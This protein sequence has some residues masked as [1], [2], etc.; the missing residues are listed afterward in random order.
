MSFMQKIGFSVIA[1]IVFSLILASS[2]DGTEN[3]TT[4][5]YV[6]QEQIDRDSLIDFLSTHF[7]DENNDIDTILNG[8][9]P[10]W[11][12]VTTKVVSITKD[13]D[14]DEIDGEVTIDYEIYYL[15]LEQGINDFPQ[16]PDSVHVSYKGMLLNGDEFDESTYGI[17][18]TMNGVVRG[19]SEGL[20][21]F[22]SGDWF[23]NP[24]T[25]FSF[26]NQGMG[27]IFMPSGLGYGHAY[28]TEIPSN[29]PLIFKVGLNMVKRTDWD[30]DG[31]L[32]IYE[33]VNN[34]GDFTDDDTDDDG[35][36]DYY[37]A[38]DDG[39]GTLTIDENPDPNGDGDPEDAQNSDG[40]FL[41]DYLDPDTT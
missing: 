19:M 22:Q 40:D 6:E 41:P 36:V 39:D 27:Y 38:D 35:Y 13:Y 23:L 4:Y 15:I 5:D 12:Q 37:D 34:N 16:Y 2:C 20:E 32:S 9:T 10:L 21:E 24:D 3:P 1:F 11:D 26:D 18:M 17:W 14:D 30:N 25:S 31:I 8:E 29:S 7:L 28:Q 33:D